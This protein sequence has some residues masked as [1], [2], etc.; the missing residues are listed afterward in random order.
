MVSVSFRS[1]PRQHERAAMLLAKRL[2][3]S[4][5][6]ALRKVRRPLDLIV[7]GAITLCL[8][9]ITIPLMTI[10]AGHERVGGWVCLYFVVI[11]Y[12]ASAVVF[13]LSGI[14]RQKTILYTTL[15]IGG[16]VTVNAT[17]VGIEYIRAGETT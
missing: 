15:G 16:D 2:G 13:S 5:I 6:R 10:F 11:V 3:D 7:K 9:L 1:H 14:L 12:V 17:E 4:K 8:L